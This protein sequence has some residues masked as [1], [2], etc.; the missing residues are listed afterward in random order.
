MQSAHHINMEILFNN[1]IFIP[2]AGRRNL[3]CAPHHNVLSWV[4]IDHRAYRPEYGKRED[5]PIIE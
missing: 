4:I 5:L 3:N 2:R 1:G